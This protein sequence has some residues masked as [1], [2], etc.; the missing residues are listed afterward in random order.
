MSV[1]LTMHPDIFPC[2]SKFL[3]DANMVNLIHCDMVRRFPSG[4]VDPFLRED[5]SLYYKLIKTDM[6]S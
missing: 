4:L 1:P 5:A 6:N 3:L 2:S